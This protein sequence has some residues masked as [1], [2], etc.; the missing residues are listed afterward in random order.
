MIEEGWETITDD[1]GR[2]SIRI[3]DG[4]IL[5]SFVDASGSAWYRPA[6]VSELQVV[7]VGR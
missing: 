3:K 4:W 1:D 5:V 7:D 6:R 2:K